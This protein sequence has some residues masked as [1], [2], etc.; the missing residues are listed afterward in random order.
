MYNMAI[1]INPNDSDAFK[2]K[3]HYKINFSGDALYNLGDIDEAIRMFDVA[4]QLNPNYSEA[5]WKKGYICIFIFRRRL[6]NFRIF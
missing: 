2:K 5:Y 1:K 4:I 3:G 6:I